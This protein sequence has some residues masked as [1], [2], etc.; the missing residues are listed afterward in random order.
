MLPL[1]SSGL[2]LLYKQAEQAKRQELPQALI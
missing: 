1:L 2:T